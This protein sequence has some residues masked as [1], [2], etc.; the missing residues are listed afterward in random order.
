MEDRRAEHAMEDRLPVRV[1]TPQADFYGP[2]VG[3]VA[4]PSARLALSMYAPGFRAREFRSAG[5]HAHPS[6]QCWTHVHNPLSVKHL[7]RVK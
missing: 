2:V 4:A 6:L 1:V 5:G 7:H 3:G